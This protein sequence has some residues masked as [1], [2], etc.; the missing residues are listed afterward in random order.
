VDSQTA[1]GTPG[2]ASRQH[3]QKQ[4]IGNFRIPKRSALHQSNALKP[5]DEIK[6]AAPNLLYIFFQF[7]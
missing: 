5:S 1:L 6:N 2:T 3:H 7:G 4:N